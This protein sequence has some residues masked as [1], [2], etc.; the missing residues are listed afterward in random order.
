LH[1][2]ARK[3][4]TSARE[5]HSP[6]WKFRAGGVRRNYKV[7]WLPIRKVLPFSGKIFFGKSVNNLIL[8][9]YRQK[10]FS[11]LFFVVTGQAATKRHKRHKI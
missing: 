8:P 3:F 1:A 9:I 11:Q 4:C 10:F 6:A 5:F 7:I 2:P